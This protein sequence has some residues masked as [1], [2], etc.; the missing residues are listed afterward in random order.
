MNEKMIVNNLIRGARTRNFKC[1]NRSNQ[2]NLRDGFI[3]KDFIRMDPWEIRYLYMIG[4]QARTGI[5]ET[6][7]YSGGSTIVFTHASLVPIY[8][9]DIAPQDD[10]KL[11]ELIEKCGLKPNLRLIVGDSQKTKYPEID[12]YDL[13]FIDADHSFEG[14]YNDLNNWWDDLEPGGHVV[15]HD[16]YLGAGTYDAVLE[17]TREKNVEWILPP[18][19][20]FDHWFLPYGSLCHF[21]KPLNSR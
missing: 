12:K 9:I 8:S 4:K 13:L 21:R 6:G 11:L 10:N 15:C 2:Y 16:C 19:I 18:Y 5:L 1:S 7:R 20:P 3:A 17:F 14:C